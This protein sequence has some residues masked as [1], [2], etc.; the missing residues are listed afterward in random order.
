[1]DLVFPSQPLL[2]LPLIIC[3]FSTSVLAASLPLLCTYIHPS[4]YLVSSGLEDINNTPKVKL[5]RTLIASLVF[6]S[7]ARKNITSILDSL[8]TN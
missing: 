1:M 4:L 5:I 7:S 3:L 6:M 2:P 8:T